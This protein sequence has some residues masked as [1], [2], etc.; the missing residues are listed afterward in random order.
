MPRRIRPPS[1]ARC[2]APA[3]RR[4]GRLRPRA[5]SAVASVEPL[6]TTMT[7]SARRVCVR[8]RV[9][10]DG[11]VVRVVQ[12]RDDDRNGAHHGESSHGERDHAAIVRTPRRFGKGLP[13]ARGA[14]LR[15]P[16][17]GCQRGH[18]HRKGRRCTH[19]HTLSRA[20][21]DGRDRDGCGVQPSRWCPRSAAIAAPAAQG[22][23]T[24]R[25]TPI[26][27]APRVRRRRRR[28]R[29]HRG[30]AGDRRRERRHPRRRHRGLRPR[31]STTSSRRSRP[32]AGT[33]RARR[34]RLHVRRPVDARAARPRCDGDVPDRA[35]HRH[36][37]RRR[38]G[39]RHPGRHRA[40]P[41]ARPARPAAARRPTSPDRLP[42]DGDIAL[43]QRGTCE[44]GVKAVNAAGR[45]APRPSSSSTRATPPLR[46]PASS[47]ARCSA[48]TRRREHP[49]R[50][51][52]L[53]RGRGARA[54]RLDG[55]H[56]RADRPSSARRRTSSRS[57]PATTTTTSS[58]PARTS[59]RCRPARASTTTAAARRPLLEIA[60]QMSKVKP[61][62]TVRLAWWGAEESGLLGS[63]G[64]RRRA[65]P[66]GERDRIAL[67][68]NFDMV[69]SPNYIF[70]VYDGDE[71]RL[72][73]P[74]GR[75]DPGGLGRRSRTSSR[76]TSPSVGEP[77]DDAEFS[78]RSDYQAFILER[79]PG[80]RPVHRR[81][82]REDR[83]AGGDLGRHRGCAVRPVLPPGVRRHRQ[84]RRS[85]RST[86]TSTRSRWPCSPTPTPRSR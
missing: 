77:Y 79:D 36:R 23:T 3:G 73:R 44:F 58:W 1:R 14:P 22:A 24:A 27:E 85:R 55:A 53:R 38:H 78:G 7:S 29:A 41:A 10:A 59:T 31:A 26:D 42:G 56:L 76:A 71:S 66:G 45:R 50:R 35:L 75:A 74:A 17:N 48:S 80:R 40:S 13:P 68:L 60:Q 61:E 18:P 54:G 2:R 83:G 65:E 21:E 19:L 5:T 84:R 63:H 33:C 49:G 4:P 11:E 86:S 30:P 57:C 37:V 81:R 52:E 9:E 15:L 62:N 69:A 64:V 34:V 20:R 47:S 82:G 6:S 67:Y 12:T 28:G 39:Q 72:R 32:P 43:I 16:R 51:R 70:M 25:T 46:D 8:E